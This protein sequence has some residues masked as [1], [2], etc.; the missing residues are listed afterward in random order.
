MALFLNRLIAPLV[1]SFIL[2]FVL[3]VSG[4]QVKK[5]FRNVLPTDSAVGYASFYANKFIGK[6]TANGD[7]F[8]Q[9]KLTCA[10][11]TLAMGTVVKVTNLKNGNTVIVT[12]NDRMHHRNPRIIDLSTSAAKKLDF[13]GSGVIKVRVEVIK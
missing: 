4:A 3:G 8:S 1:L 6:K 7:I 11:N 13:N 5:N 9:E 10:H 12:V 2:S